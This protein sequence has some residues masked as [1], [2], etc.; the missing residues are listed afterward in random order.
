MYLKKEELAAEIRHYQQSGRCS[1]RL[2]GMLLRL[3]QGVAQRFARD[4][5]QEDV[6][7]EGV[8]NLLVALPKFQPDRCQALTFA[9]SCV[10]RTIFTLRRK[11]RSIQ[12]L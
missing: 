8:L 1:E 10:I 3:A 5:E 4:L 9:T 2:G 12:K 11:Q 7:S 6:I